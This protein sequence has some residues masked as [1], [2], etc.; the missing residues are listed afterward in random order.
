MMPKLLLI[1]FTEQNAKV[2]QMFIEINFPALT[3]M[4]ISRQLDGHQLQF[5]AL[6]PVH[7]GHDVFVIDAEGVGFHG[8]NPDDAISQLT[9]QLGD[10]P[11]LLIS[12]HL[13]APHTDTTTHSPQGTALSRYRWLNVPYTRQQM[14]DNIQA[15]LDYSAAQPATG[16]PTPSPSDPT[17][18]TNTG[19]KTDIDKPIDTDTPSQSLNDNQAAN[20][21]QATSQSRVADSQSIMLIFDII[22]KT[23]PNIEQTA[24]FQFAK[25]LQM[26]DDYACIEVNNHHLYVNPFDN[27][28]VASRLARIIDQFRVSQT[29]GHTLYKV[30]PLDESRFK[31]QTALHLNQGDKHLMISQ[32][33][34]FMG[35]EVLSRNQYDMA[36]H[37]AIEVNYMPNL[38][39]TNFVPS[40]VT[41]MIASCLGRPRRLVELNS[42]FPTLTVAQSNQ[43]LIL[44][45]MSNIINAQTLIQSYQRPLAATSALA[46]D[47]APKASV[48]DNQAIVQPASNA[49]IKKASE[50]GFLKRFLGRLGAKFS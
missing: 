5:P 38:T 32:V 10:K 7:L 4:T 14:F 8:A 39:G 23:F 21:H 24:F 46:S 30:S 27:S 48:A 18:G 41:P 35:L 6:T 3:L 49:G 26:I 28:V 17:I 29:T 19:V 42:L 43:V 25:Q 9:T 37:L 34:W 1:G 13:N 15:L 11:A 12:R 2:I 50:S 20:H 44:M 31:E 36:H 16:A 22:A 33:I 47:T 40:Y 45:M